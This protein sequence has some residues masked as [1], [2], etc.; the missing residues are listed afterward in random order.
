MF[1]SDYKTEGFG[2]IQVSNFFF[3]Y[4]EPQPLLCAA[5]R[6]ARV[7][8]TITCSPT[9]LNYCVI[10]IAYKYKIYKYVGGPFNKRA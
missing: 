8:L 10:F 4:K 9:L 1:Y 7:Q 5:S 6:A 3:F 2:L